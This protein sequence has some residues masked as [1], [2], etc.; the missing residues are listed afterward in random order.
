MPSP[1]RLIK[2]DEPGVQYRAEANL[3]VWGAALC[4]LIAIALTAIGYGGRLAPVLAGP[5]AATFL[6]WAA[7]LAVTFVG[8]RAERYTLT[9]ARLTIER[10]I[11]TRHHEDIELWRIREVAFEQTWL[12]R[13]RGAGRITLF[14]IDAGQ[15]SIRVGPVARA[16]AFYDELVAATQ[17][18]DEHARPAASSSRSPRDSR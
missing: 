15:P 7:Y 8:R 3:R 13:M 16:R 17:K 1:L 9:P 6:L 18:S 2:L 11:V 12:E 5:F 4:G 10:G 14:A